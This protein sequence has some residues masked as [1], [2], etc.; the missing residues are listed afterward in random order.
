MRW[1]IVILGTAAIAL[2]AAS[3][4]PAAACSLITDHPLRP[5]SAFAA[6]QVAPLPPTLL[7]YE[8]HRADLGPGEHVGDGSC[9][10]EGWIYLHVTGADDLTPVDQLGYTVVADGAVD[11]TLRFLTDPRDPLGDTLVLG[12]L[13]Q[14]QDL[15]LRVAIRAVDRN[16]NA[17]APLSVRITDDVGCAA[18]GRGSAGGLVLAGAALLAL[19]RHRPR[20]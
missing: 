11:P 19:R 2:L 14:D 5:D 4:R 16:L 12:F 17:S 15:D 3:P 6:D 20:R 18:G 1:P 8:V 9:A 13:N 7:G 10:G